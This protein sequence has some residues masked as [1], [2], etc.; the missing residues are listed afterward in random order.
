MT[1]LKFKEF[2]AQNAIYGTVDKVIGRLKE[3]ERV[4][5]ETAFLRFPKSMQEEKMKFFAER[6]MKSLQS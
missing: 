1:S 2:L 3:Y 5:V 4:G 6:L